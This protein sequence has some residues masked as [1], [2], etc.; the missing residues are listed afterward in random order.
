M[1]CDWV[2]PMVQLAAMT[3]AEQLPV[4]A[5][6]GVFRGNRHHAHGVPKLGERAQDGGFRDL[7]TEARAQLHGGECAFAFEQLPR[8]GGERG[9]ARVARGGW[10]ALGVA[11]RLQR[12]EIGQRFG[13]GEEVRVLAHEAGD[14]DAGCGA[15]EIQRNDRAG[16]DEACEHPGGGGD[17]LRI[18]CGFRP[19]GN[20]FDECG[21]R[22]G[23]MLAA[24]Q[25]EAE[26]RVGEPALRVVEREQ[27]IAI[28]TPT[29]LPRLF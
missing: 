27:R 28:L 29:Y 16:R 3:R 1:V 17:L 8:L 26:R 14:A 13:G 10:L 2:L 11:L 24:G 9:D 19:A 15:E 6:L 18:R 25:I 7:S 4:G 5:F 21:R 12:V 23:Q 22:H 20:G